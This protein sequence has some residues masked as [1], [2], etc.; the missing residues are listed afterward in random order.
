MLRFFRLNDPYRL[1]G[2]LILLIAMSLP[3]LINPMSSTL[4]ELKDI[5]LGE[6]L[7]SGKTMYLQVV[8]DAPWFASWL[9]GV[10][11]M[12][13]GR[14]LLA[15]HLIAVFIIFFQAAF[16]AFML[17]RNR[18]YNESNY[19]PAFVFGALCFFSFDLLSLSRQLFAST[20]LLLALNNIFK[21]IEFKVQRDEIVLNIG[22]F[23]GIASLLVFS[24]SI[25]LI[26][27]LIILFVFAR[28][29]LRKSLLLAF[30][31]T[32]PHLALICLYYFRGGLPELIQYFYGAAFTLHPIGLISWKSIFSLSGGVLIF[33]FFSLI[34][35][36]RNA[37]FT[38]YQSQLLQV[39]LLWL[40]ASSI[41]IG[42]TPE[43][44]P[45]SFITFVPTLTYFISHYLLLIRRKWI[46]ET[47]V[48][49]F[50]LSTIGMSTVARKG[51]VKSIDYKNLF[52]GYSKYE[53]FVMGK[54]VLVLGSDWGIYKNNKPSSYFL[55]WELSKEFFE[56][57]DYFE[58][59]VLIQ[60]AFEAEMPEVIVDEK[61]L[62]KNVFIKLPSLRGQY[63]QAGSI[64][65]RKLKKP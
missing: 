7:N 40:I 12:V 28:I 45:H 13:V 41:E 36:N 1:L 35:L 42:I 24:Y 60:N 63:E 39:M 2:V 9:A 44:T 31:F 25:F 34:M 14:S 33:F 5:V 49:V 51:K 55:N 38:K 54:R 29:T 8:D 37:R 16:F 32:F 52:V 62:M 65:L 47:M 21:E 50:L 61:G 56:R 6:L 10:I 27:A 23:I 18:A 3:L 59:I 20:F 43:L 30:G 22:V 11:E 15:R 19:L 17:I 58:N 53:S 64:Y 4:P 46:A 26:G 57:P 48:W